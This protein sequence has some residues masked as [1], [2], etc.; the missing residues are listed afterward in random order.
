[1]TLQHPTDRAH[2]RN[3]AAKAAYSQDARQK[4][5]VSR[6]KLD[7]VTIAVRQAIIVGRMKS[8]PQLDLAVNAM[9]ANFKAAETQLRAL[10][11]SGEDDWDA[12]R[13]P[14][15]SAWENLAHSIKNLVARY[16]DESTVQFS[17]Q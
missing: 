1:M 15:E 9:E 7:G 5:V 4:L 16:A 8:S 12:L 2:S 3:A 10:Q 11:E 14:L 6:S 17:G 13:I